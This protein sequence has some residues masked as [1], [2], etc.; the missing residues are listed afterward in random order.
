MTMIM[1]MAMLYCSDQDHDNKYVHYTDDDTDNIKFCIFIKTMSDFDHDKV[2]DYDH[3]I[4]YDNNV[5]PH[6]TRY[7]S[8]T[9]A[10]VSQLQSAQLCA[11][12]YAPGATKYTVV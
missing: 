2:C 9:T 11:N 10:P 1:I 3:E 4:Y 6:L 7:A 12:L 8:S 5:I